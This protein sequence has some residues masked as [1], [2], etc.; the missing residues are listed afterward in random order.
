MICSTPGCTSS[1]IHSSG[2]CA[3]HYFYRHDGNTC[4]Q[5]TCGKVHYARGLCRTHYARLQTK[6][7]LD[8]LERVSCLWPGCEKLVFRGFCPPH[9]TQASRKRKQYG[10]T[11]EE[12]IAILQGGCQIC[13]NTATAIDHCHATGRVRGGLCSSCNTGLGLFRD[14]PDLLRSAADYLESK[15]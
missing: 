3:T 10:M 2:M 8:L 12:Y 1:K 7:N 9:S 5:E 15:T 13:G 4:S 14:R 11:P 6:G